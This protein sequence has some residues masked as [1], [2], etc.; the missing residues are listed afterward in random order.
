MGWSGRRVGR[1]S[2][3]ACP[4]HSAEVAVGPGSAVPVTVVSTGSPH[5][6]WCLVGGYYYSNSNGCPGSVLTMRLA[7]H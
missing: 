5:T 1:G 2:L 6:K 4:F 7:Q 3:L